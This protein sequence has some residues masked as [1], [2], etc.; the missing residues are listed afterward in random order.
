MQI[1]EKRLE[2]LRPYE[3]NPRKNDKAVEKVAESIR[4]FGFKV[5][6][7][8]DENG[9]IVAG[10]TRY[11]AAQALEMETIHCIVADDLTEQQIKA[12]RLADNKVAEFSEWEEI[13]LLAELQDIDEIDMRAFGFNMEG[14]ENLAEGWFE[15]RK[16]NEGQQEGNQEYNKFLEKFEIKKTTDDCYTPDNIYDAVAEWV[17]AEYKIQR[18]H[19]VRPF[20]PGGDYQKENY[21]KRSVVVDNPPF[22]I[23]SEI[24]NW[25]QESGIRFFLFAPAQTC[26]KNNACAVCAG[27]EI[28]YENGAIVSTSFLTN[29]EENR[30]RSAPDLYAKI[31]KQNEI[32]RREKRK[33]IKAHEYPTEVVTASMLSYLSK[34]GVDLTISKEES[35]EKIGALDAQKKNGDGIFGGAFLLSEK[36]AAEKAAAKKWELSEREKEIVRGLGK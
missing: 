13:N 34:H 32:N 31:K 7:V 5:P 29:M 24:V 21:T 27:G 18:K 9:E 30:A 22:S 10:H 25:Y 6:I 20:Y 36:A 17:A 35:S 1:I 33:E 11:R 2:A 28:E 23:L 4:E 19:F 16:R 3:H 12:F 8:I 26:F 15:N 14:L